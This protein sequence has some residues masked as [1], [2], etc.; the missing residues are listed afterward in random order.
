MEVE[1][2]ASQPQAQRSV[3]QLRHHTH[4]Q[5]DV[6]L[7]VQ[8]GVVV[9]QVHAD[10]CAQTTYP[11]IVKPTHL[12]VIH[13]FERDLRLVQLLAHRTAEER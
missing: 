8:I 11:N 3:L 9:W 7:H 2:V 12:G 6:R 1:Q 4:H 10:H 13:M 5:L